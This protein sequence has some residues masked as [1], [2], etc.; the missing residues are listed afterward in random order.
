MSHDILLIEDNPHDVEMIISAF[1]EHRIHVPVRSLKDGAEALDYLFGSEG[2][3]RKGMGVFP[4]VILLDLKLPKVNGLEIRDPQEDPVGCKDPAHPGR[5]P[6][7]LQRGK[8]PDRELQARG[9]QLYREA[10]RL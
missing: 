5:R 8:G 6:D 4:K 1:K 10:G 7:I 2:S 9:Q 3:A